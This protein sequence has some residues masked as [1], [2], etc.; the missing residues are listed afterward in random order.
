[1]SVAS[2]VRLV[3]N[4]GVPSRFFSG[5]PQVK[6]AYWACCARSAPVQTPST[7]GIALAAAVSMPRII[8][9][10]WEERTIQA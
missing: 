7:P 3:C 8:P 4:R 1:L 2:A 6:G 10:A 5:N 9:W